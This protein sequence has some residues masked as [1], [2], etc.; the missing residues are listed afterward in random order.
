MQTEWPP[1]PRASAN[2]DAAREIVLADEI[3][4]SRPASCVFEDEHDSKSNDDDEERTSLVNRCRRLITS[5]CFTGRQM[6]R[7]GTEA[8]CRSLNVIQSLFQ[9]ASSLL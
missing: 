8:L 6:A 4:L 9:N 2:N 7:L 3:E 5:D 1:V